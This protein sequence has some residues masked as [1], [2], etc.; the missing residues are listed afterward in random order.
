MKAKKVPIFNQI[1]ML[2]PSPMPQIAPISAPQVA[3]CYL[4][5]SNCVFW[6]RSIPYT[7]KKALNTVNFTYVPHLCYEVTRCFWSEIYM[8]HKIF[9]LKVHKAASTCSCEWDLQ[10]FGD[11]PLRETSKKRL[12]IYFYRRSSSA[13]KAHDSSDGVY[14][15]TV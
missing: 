6:M 1:C 13:T 12:Y 3:T 10:D 5:A 9:V 7:Q 4:A 11:P 14:V 2:L 15:L 8:P